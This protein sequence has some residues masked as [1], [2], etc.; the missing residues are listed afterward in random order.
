MAETGTTS[1]LDRFRLT[2]SIDDLLQ[3]LLEELG[4]LV[5]PFGQAEILQHSGSF[6]AFMRPVKAKHSEEILMIKFSPDFLVLKPNDCKVFFAMDTKFSITPVFFGAQINRIREHSKQPNLVREDIGDIERE[7]WLVYNRYFPA[8][9]VVI[10]FATPYNPNVLLA[11]WVS[12]IKC[13][14]CFSQKPTVPVNCSKCPIFG[15]GKGTFGV[16]QNIEA[17]GSSTPHT[18]INLSTMRPLSKF[19]E[20]EFKINIPKLLYN[21]ILDEI[22]KQP[23][24]KPKGR[25]NWTQFNNVVKNLHKT[26]PWLYGYKPGRSGKMIKIDFAEELHLKFKKQ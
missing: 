19:L 5:Q 18:N 4:F 2:K 7:A 14:Y 23:L 21:A 13:L 15:S 8:D 24:N 11:E 22:K 26:C 20:E 17:G 16:V 6:Q 25:V 1:Y 10:A 3:P 12:N 9:Q